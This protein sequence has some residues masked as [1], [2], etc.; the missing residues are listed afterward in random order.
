MLFEYVLFDTKT[1]K[2]FCTALMSHLDADAK[3][4]RLRAVGRSQRWILKKDLPEDTDK[5]LIGL[6][7]WK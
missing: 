5:S 3:N 1:K 4:D 7:V 6:G 2:Q